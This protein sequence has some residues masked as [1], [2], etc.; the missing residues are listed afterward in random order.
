MKTPSKTSICYLQD[1]D[2]FLDTSC[3]L[4]IFQHHTSTFQEKSSLFQNIYQK[5]TQELQPTIIS[6]G[7]GFCL[8]YYGSLIITRERR[9]SDLLLKIL[10]MLTESR[11]LGRGVESHQKTPYV[12]LKLF[13]EGFIITYTTRIM[14]D[15]NPG[16]MRLVSKQ[17]IFHFH[18]C[19]RMSKNGDRYNNLP[20]NWIIRKSDKTRRIFTFFISYSND[21]WVVSSST[22]TPGKDRWLVTY[23][24]PLNLGVA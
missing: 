18:D 14:E 9:L 10:A 24:P 20:I 2:L 7:F 4:H 23:F 11:F 5:T 3:D 22:A 21:K 15:W 6:R 1:R 17:A 16:K 13:L 8:S 12:K 19:R